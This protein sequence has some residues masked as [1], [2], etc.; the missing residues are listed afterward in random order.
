MSCSQLVRD[1]SGYC[2]AHLQAKRQTVK[3]ERQQADKDRG[4]SAQRG[5]GYR[6][7]KLR[8]AYLA[9]HQTCAECKR[10][11][12][13]TLAVIVDHITPHKGDMALFWDSSNWQPLC[14]PCHDRKTATEDG[15][16]GRG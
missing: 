10:Q 14:K 2:A 13:L 1:G 9:S 7:Q 6:W 15:G 12:R 11:G 5:Y 8:G 3:V 16:W 4:T